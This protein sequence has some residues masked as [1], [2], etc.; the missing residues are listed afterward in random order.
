M[1]SHSHICERLAIQARRRTADY[2][3]M[4]LRSDPRR[5]E[6]V[7]PNVQYATT[8]AQHVNAFPNPATGGTPMQEGALGPYVRAI[9][10]H[11]P[12]VIAVTLVTLLA[13][14]AWLQV[15]T[16]E[17]EASS[18]LLVTPVP[19]DDQNFLGLQVL[20]D[21]G[22]P[23][24]T[25][26]TAA[27]LIKSPQAARATA[28]RVDGAWTPKKVLDSVDVQPQGQSNIL[29]VTATAETPEGA[30]RVANAFAREALIVR[31]RAL[32]AQI[33]D[34][35]ARLRPRL[36]TITDPRNAPDLIDQIDKL[37]AVQAKGDPTLSLSQLA[38]PPA[39]ETAAGAQLVIPL[40]ILAGLALG[41]GAA[42]L[43]ELFARRIRDEGELT[44]L[45]PLPV[46]VRVPTIPRRS[47]RA[48]GRGYWSMAPAVHEAFRT[49]LVQLDVSG[50]GPRTLMVTSATTG[51]GKTTSA[52]NLAMSI[53]AVGHSVVLMDL[54]LRKSDVARTLGVVNSK[55]LHMLLAPD[56][57]G[58]RFEALL[59]PVPSA[60]SVR[61]L[62]TTSAPQN[63]ALVDAFERR[64]PDLIQEAA[65]VAEFVVIDTPPLGEVADALR[66]A[67]AVDGI[68]LV[69]RPGKTIRPSFEFTRDLLERAGRRPLGYLLIGG[70][71]APYYHSYG[72]GADGTT[73]SKAGAST[74]RLR[75]AEAPGARETG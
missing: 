53:S 14:L 35:L 57:S 12:L 42:L 9:R 32:S 15:R 61:L 3:W 40:A 60:P 63:V 37:E 2:N 70:T 73:S 48:L 20:R 34:E 36:R 28:Q 8:L 51:D 5:Y 49:I 74:R 72:Y 25:V 17:Y 68:I 47:R 43:L 23:T 30:A 13:S 7:R 33:D 1:G 50:E 71:H 44:S 41:S 56:L 55:P 16:P 65:K 19:Q 11:K 31:G 22:D 46:L 66:F 26:E 54:D 4:T 24:R 59:E 52:I 64:A 18:Q 10:S 27:T 67:D 69:A 45:Y 38:T 62:S 58:M 39:G 75:A 6:A 21:S 29:A